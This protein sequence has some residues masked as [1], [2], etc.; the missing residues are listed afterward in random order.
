M[1]TVIILVRKQNRI[2]HRVR[3]L[4]R[5]DG[6]RQAFFAS[7]IHAVRKH[8][9]RFPSLLFSGHF[10]RRQINGVVKQ[11][12][13][14]TVT[15]AAAAATAAARIVRIAAGATAR[16]LRKLW[17]SHLVQ[18]GLQFLPRRR[19]ILQQ[20]HFAI[21]VNQ[22]GLIA[23]LAQYVIHEG[24]AGAALPIQKPPLAH[25]G[26]HQQSQ[27]QRQIGLLREIFY[28]LRMPILLQN[29]IILG[30]ILD[31]FSVFVPHAGQHV[32]DAHVDGNR[33]GLGEG[34]SL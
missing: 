22:K 17:S 19:Q 7:A 1:I 15:T 29:K 26:V 8:D 33:R 16:R 21:E 25:A 4:R 28:R 9:Q 30:Q 32:Y 5:S 12:S 23:I 27:D 24:P 18:R 2:D 6:L 20:L 13:A 34:C 11:R 3:A 10:V 14:A 31:Q